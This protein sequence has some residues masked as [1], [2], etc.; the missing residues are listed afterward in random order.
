MPVG[1]L[2][3]RSQ[4]ADKEKEEDAEERNDSRP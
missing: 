1:R 3:Q 2:V 4:F